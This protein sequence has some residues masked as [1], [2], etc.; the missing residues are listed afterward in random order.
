MSQFVQQQQQHQEQHA[1]RRKEI[2][3]SGH[4]WI[5]QTNNKQKRP[6]LY[7][8][9]KLA[10]KYRMDN[11]CVIAFIDNEDGILLVCPCETLLPPSP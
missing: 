3:T 9:V 2:Y 7:L 6:T 11:P 4:P 8:P 10:E 5:S 1:K